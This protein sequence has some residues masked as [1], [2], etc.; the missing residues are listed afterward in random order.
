MPAITTDFWQL[1]ADIKH[2][3]EIEAELDEFLG[4]NAIDNANEKLAS[5]MEVD[6]DK[7]IEEIIDKRVNER[8]KRSNQKEKAQHRKNYSGGSK[9]Q[10]PTPEK[11][12][13]YG[14][15][16]QKEKSKNLR[17]RSE[18]RSS[19]TYTRNNLHYDYDDDDSY[20][21]KSRK[22]SSSRTRRT[23]E[24]QT[25]N[26]KPHP[27]L[28]KKGVTFHRS[29]S[30][31][32]KHKPPP[33]N[34]TNKNGNLRNNHTKSSDNYHGRGRGRGGRGGSRGGGRGRSGRRN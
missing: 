7:A 33:Q 18:K 32:G 23:K 5:M 10:D 34:S 26:D 1:Q 20:E 29:T 9:H 11:T 27:I 15:A 2:D 8:L 17:G 14:K 30:K 13:R 24:S 12:G 21:N 4:R 22:R 31:E 19:S 28:R 3:A 6:G 25:T 16:Q